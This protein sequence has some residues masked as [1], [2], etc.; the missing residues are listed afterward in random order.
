MKPTLSIKIH[1]EISDD[2]MTY[3]LMGL[4]ALEHKFN[5]RLEGFKGIDISDDLSTA[6]SKIMARQMQAKL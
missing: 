4:S 1:E 3:L 5:M 2:A 6:V